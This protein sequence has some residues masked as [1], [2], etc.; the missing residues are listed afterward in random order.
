MVEKQ[1]ERISEMYT[2]IGVKAE[3]FDLLLNQ[4]KEIREEYTAL[5]ALPFFSEYMNVCKR[6]QHV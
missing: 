3:E 4:L 5:A 1:K 2:Q 6:E